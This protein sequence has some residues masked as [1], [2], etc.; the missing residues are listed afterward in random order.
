MQVMKYIKYFVISLF[1][2]LMLLVPYLYF[3]VSRIDPKTLTSQVTEIMQSAG[4]DKVQFEEASM[5]YFPYPTIT[6][7]RLSVNEGIF[8]DRSKVYLNI[9]SLIKGG[10]KFNAIEFNEIY[11]DPKKLESDQKTINDYIFQ[12]SNIDSSIYKIS[13]NKIW[14]T[15][16]R[17]TLVMKDL[18]IT[19]T[20]KNIAI[21]FSLTNDIKYKDKAIYDSESNSYSSTLY[22]SNRN[23]SFSANRIFDSSGTKSGDFTG[24]INNLGSFV[25]DISSYYDLLFLKYVKSSENVKISGKITND[26]EYTILQNIQIKGKNL[27]AYSNYWIARKDSSYSIL[28]VNFSKLDL[29]S[30]SSG[31]ERNSSYEDSVSGLNALRLKMK[32]QASNIHLVNEPISDFELLGYGAG[33]TFSINSC[34]GSIGSSGSFLI[35]GTIEDN[36]FRPKFNGSL[37]L[38]HNNI[39]K[40][41]ENSFVNEYTQKNNSSIDVEGN[42]SISP[43]DLLIKDL[44]LTIAGQ[45]IKGSANLKFSGAE[46]LILGNLEFTNLDLASNQIPLINEV[47]SYF[48]SLGYDMFDKSYVSKFVPLRNF[49]IKSNLKLAAQNLKVE[50]QDI[51][52]FSIVADIDVGHIN[53][54]DFFISKGKTYIRG[55]GDIMASGLKPI[56]K[57]N[58]TDGEVYADSVSSDDIDFMLQ[59]L[60]QNVNLSALDISGTLALKTLNVGS[61]AS[62]DISGSIDDQKNSLSTKLIFSSMSG[63]GSLE[64][65]MIFNP[66]RSNFSYVLERFEVVPLASLFSDSIPLKSGIGSISGQISATGVNSSE[67]YK[68][69]Y[70]NG[71][72][73]GGNINVN[74]IDIEGLIGK[75]S[76]TDI[77]YKSSTK[78]FEES[79]NSGSTN[80]DSLKFSYELEA[81]KI[82]SKN[83]VIGSK[84]FDGSSTLL[85]DI[86]NNNIG[87]ESI[88]NFFPSGAIVNNPAMTKPVK[89]KMAAKGNIFSPE[90][91]LTFNSDADI[92]Y[93]KELLNARINGNFK[94]NK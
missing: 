19:K 80:L 82:T 48:K 57:F 78:A 61:F 46:Q 8:I 38:N 2:V 15:T 30:L 87:I 23:F 6:L 36:G 3:M 92:V 64:G 71:K 32:V 90:K 17:N 13:C 77:D 47:Y 43:V 69:L 28:D 52:R 24:D 25:S 83:I 12:S 45:S 58:L 27:E 33:N 86:A 68:N 31:F 56:V 9:V 35:S 49:P 91:L 53:V 7:R 76:K 54:D 18:V 41:L 29:A 44:K 37:A 67:I 59:Y 10:I 73:I 39:G 94:R 84:I 20:N 16:V 55:K 75:L 79:V 50:K 65:N 74:N 11:L 81:K 42:I 22:I 93:I 60:N 1:V 5:D 66:L 62:S 34:K 89:L 14:D 88:F 40:L 21:E 51:D 26:S 63:K 85:I 72:F 70:I 4:M